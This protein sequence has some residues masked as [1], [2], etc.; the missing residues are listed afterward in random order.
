MPVR[1]LTEIRHLTKIPHQVRD[2]RVNCLYYGEEY[3]HYYLI[4]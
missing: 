2:D 4:P 3:C 1:Q